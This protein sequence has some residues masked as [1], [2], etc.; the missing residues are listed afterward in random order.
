M[1]TWA[2]SLA[3]GHSWPLWE[4]GRHFD[5]GYVL[6]S[7]V[8]DVISPQQVG[9]L[10]VQ[11]S[12]LFECDLLNQNLTWSGGVFDIFGLERGRSITREQALAHYSEDSRAKLDSLRAYAI[13]H[14][15]GF[16][17]DVE[18]RAAAVGE[19]RHVRLI[20][21]PELEGHEAVRLSGL[22]LII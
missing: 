13:R 14:R 22:K 20:A 8:T 21:A 10:A 3:L 2:Y 4:S 15:R 16:T 18:I 9:G 12:G 1:T 7:V 5:L 19:T 6:N 17:L 11:H